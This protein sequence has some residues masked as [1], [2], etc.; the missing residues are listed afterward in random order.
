LLGGL[1]L[2]LTL[3]A[4]D[5]GDGSGDPTATAPPTDAIEEQAA[6]SATPESALPLD[7]YH[8]VALLTLRE[9]RPEG[10]REVV[11]S[12]EGDYQSPDRHA[13]THSIRAGSEVYARSAVVMGERA[14]YRLSQEAWQPVTRQD[15]RLTSL[16]AT[17]FSPLREGFL[18]GP[19]FD[20]VRK[21]VRR[22]TPVVEQVNG[23]PA[24]H[25]E[26]DALGREF[27]LGFLLDDGSPDVQDLAWDLWL[28]ADGG[29]PVRLV[30]S[31]TMAAGSPALDEL[32]LAAP[33]TWELR[34]DIS[35]PN[36][37]AL[38]VAAPS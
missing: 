38:A 36:D 16:A 37:P 4:C 27:V 19:S 7:R 5:D 33:V 25:Y 23:V 10:A 21:N 17:A 30:A 28:A 14:W 34:I 31:G 9:T 3:V 18:G 29:W 6:P 1:L 8:Y 12:T 22:L 20:E 13:F 35:R 24:D 2:S 15:D 11:I 32:E 26:V